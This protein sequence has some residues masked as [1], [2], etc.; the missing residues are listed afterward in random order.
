MLEDENLI[1]IENFLKEPISDSAR[2][3]I[4]S[5]SEIKDKTKL[6]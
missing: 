3:A 2:K 5:L 1:N 6:I 4:N